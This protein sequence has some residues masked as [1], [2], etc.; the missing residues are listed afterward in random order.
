MEAGQWRVA[1]HGLPRS[2]ADAGPGWRDP[3][4]GGPLVAR[5]PFVKR[6]RP[7]PLSD[8][9]HT[10]DRAAERT[11]A[12]GFSAGAAHADEP[13]FNYLVAVPSLLGYARPV[14][15]HVKYLVS[16]P[17]RPIACL[18]WCSAPR[19]LGARDR[20]IGWSARRGAATSVSSPTTLAISFCLG[21]GPASGV[22]RS[23]SDG[24][25]DLADWER[26]Y[27]HPIYFLETFVDPERYRGTCYRAA[28]WVVMGRTTGRG[29]NDQTQRP[30]R[31]IKEVFGF[32]LHPQFRELLRNI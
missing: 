6:E 3:T 32:P 20:F 4:S 2:A 9:H 14:G 1:R 19:H 10:G 16:A 18:A 23:R 27:G 28:N 22:A 15:E 13:L 7:Q 26:I 17:G 11:A 30:N 5:N 29:K 12:L 21:S 31:S 8:R 25:A 24:A